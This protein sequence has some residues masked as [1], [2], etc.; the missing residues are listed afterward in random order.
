MCTTVHVITL[1]SVLDLVAFVWWQ[2]QPEKKFMFDCR[3]ASA[4]PAN[5]KPWQERLQGLYWTSCSCWQCLDQQSCCH[6]AHDITTSAHAISKNLHKNFKCESATKPVKVSSEKS[7][8]PH[9]TL[10]IYRDRTGI[11]KA[12]RIPASF[13][14]SCVSWF[15]SHMNVNWMKA[16]MQ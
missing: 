16:N 14:E 12:M 6:H 2:L 10:T 3:Q 7:A 5:P 1:V 15:W 8:I 11:A 4:L 13:A 9:R